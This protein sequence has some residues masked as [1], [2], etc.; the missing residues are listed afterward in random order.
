MSKYKISEYEYVTIFNLLVLGMLQ[1]QCVL[2]LY[3]IQANYSFIL[4]IDIIFIHEYF[5]E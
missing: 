5:K 3:F 4:I 2:L 1:Y